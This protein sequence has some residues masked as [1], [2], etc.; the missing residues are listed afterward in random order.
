MPDKS[1][2][3]TETIPTHIAFIMD[4]NGRWGTR[5]RL[6]RL[7]GHRAGVQNLRRLAEDA[8]KLGLRFMTAYAFSTENWTRPE[9]E[10][11]GL[12][13]LFRE[14]CGQFINDSRKNNIRIA[15]IGD[16]ARFDADLRRRI[17]QLADVTKAK[18]GLTLILALNYG[19]RDDIVRAARRLCEDAAKGR[20][21]PGEV[22]EAMFS[23]SLDTARF[24]DPDLIIRTAGEMR[25]SNF[26][27]WQSAY[28]EFYF[29]DKYFPDFRIADLIEA[30]DRFNRRDRRF[31]G[32]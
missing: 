24:P 32:I 5:K 26:L 9:E 3:T 16:T 11:S 27:L 30:I 29:S 31:G 18:T 14:Y 4:G 23:G 17:D 28:A 15:F 13:E 10:V 25:L 8:D 20:L 2:G 1:T 22:T 7:A 6:P 19:G 21:S 12:M